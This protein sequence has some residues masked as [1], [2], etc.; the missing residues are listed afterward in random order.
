MKYE[1]KMMKC[2]ICHKE[3]KQGT[4]GWLYQCIPVVFH[5]EQNEGMGTTPY[6]DTKTYIDMC[7]EC[8]KRFT[9]EYPLHAWGAQGYNT[10]KWK[11]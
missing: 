10:Y 6:L 8:V 5:T 4:D 11:E 2:D 9:D 7:P 3:D 1:I